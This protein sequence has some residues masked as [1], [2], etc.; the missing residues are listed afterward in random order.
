MKV[1]STRFDDQ[2]LEELEKIKKVYEKEQ[3]FNPN[4]S[5]LI[6]IAV[7]IFIEEKRKGK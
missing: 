6:R 1:I 5:D 2:E 3:H 4:I 7:K